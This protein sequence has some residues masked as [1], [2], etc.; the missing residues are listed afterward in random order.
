MAR[1][2]ALR[3][4]LGGAAAAIGAA[5]LS[6]G[7][8]E[9][10]GANGPPVT[11]TLYYTSTDPV[12]TI[13]GDNTQGGGAVGVYG[14]GNVGVAGGGTAYGVDGSGGTAGVH[15]FGNTANA[16][17]VHGVGTAGAGVYGEG[18]V[19]VKGVA[20]S[21]GAGVEG[22]NFGPGPGVLGNATG[23]GYGV[24]GISVGGSNGYGV[25]GSANN[26]VN[27]VGVAG[28]STTGYG[29]LGFTSAPPPAAGA[30]A[31]NAS[32]GGTALS[33]FSSASTG[34]GVGVYGATNSAA[35]YGVY[36][37]A[38][39]TAHA[40]WF[41]G[42]VTVNGNFNV[43]GT[44]LAVVRDNSGSL[45]SMYCVESPECWFEDFGSARL[46]GG[47]AKVQVD[48][49]FAELVRTDNYSVFLT[50]EGEAETL[51]VTGKTPVAFQVKEGHGGTS[52][53]EFSYR[54]VAKRK[55][56]ARATRTHPGSGTTRHAAGAGPDP[57]AGHAPA[58]PTG[59]TPAARPLIAGRT[60]SA[61]C[62]LSDSRAEMRT[63]RAF[64]GRPYLYPYRLP[65]SAPTGSAAGYWTPRSFPI[66]VAHRSHECRCDAIDNA[67]PSSRRLARKAWAIQSAATETTATGQRGARAPRGHRQGS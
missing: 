34:A 60:D 33:A 64:R 21:P 3:A 24:Q 17:G 52:S 59:A 26:G 46:S 20:N 16:Y 18:G 1:R 13:E 4:V 29:F 65:L 44:K 19:G 62:N 31:S 28:V 51:H 41:S 35:G 2:F 45:R 7:R 57:R 32:P 27:A 48:P 37:A 66:P 22:D 5:L 53:V 6:A 58:S 38:P 55:D 25:Y 56:V 39:A 67:D 15:G 43:T 8:P 54:I 23:G 14:K 10:A 11:G 9:P 47:S 42:N 61:V 40:G 36:G 30:A 49:E 50:A 12:A 63:D